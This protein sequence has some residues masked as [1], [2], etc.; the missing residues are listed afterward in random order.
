MHG[1]F[2]FS[3]NTVMSTID[4]L[5]LLVSAYPVID[6][7]DLLAVSSFRHRD[8]SQIKVASA[9]FHLGRHELRGDPK[10]LIREAGDDS[11]CK[12]SARQ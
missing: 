5:Q 4:G 12:G 7:C 1:F 2:S 6:H 11:S 3:V 10:R 9:F 8:K